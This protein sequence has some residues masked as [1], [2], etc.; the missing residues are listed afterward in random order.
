MLLA[1]AA[2]A[3]AQP[4]FEIHGRVV[5]PGIGA[6]A[7]A[8]VVINTFDEA[9]R[10]VRSDGQG[11]FR[12]SVEHA[13][14]YFVTAGKSG[15]FGSMAR[16]LRQP[17]LLTAAQPVGECVVEL[18]QGGQ[19][20]GRVVDEKTR[21]P[22]AGVDVYLL[23][24]TWNFGQVELVKAVRQSVKTESDGRFLFPAGLMP[25]DYVVAAWARWDGAQASGS[26]TKADTEA[27]DATYEEQYWPGGGDATSS[28]PVHLDSRGYG[29]VGAVYVRK[30]E[31]Y[32]AV[33]TIGKGCTEDDQVKLILLKRDGGKGTSLG[34][35]ECGSQ[36]LLRGLDPGS[37]AL[38]AVSSHQ[39]GRDDLE[40]ALT[41]G[42][43]FEIVDKN[44][45]VSVP[46][47]PISVIEGQLVVGEGVT[48][49]QVTPRIST[50][51]VDVLPGAEAL[52]ETFLVWGDNGRFRLGVT[53][54]AQRL[55]VSPFAGQHYVKEIRYGGSLVNDMV[56][57]A[58]SGGPPKLEIVLSDLKS[59]ATG[60]VT[61]GSR[62]VVDAVVLV[63]PEG[64][65]AQDLA[66]APPANNVTNA[67]GNFNV[68]A[69]PGAYRIVAVTRDGRER[70]NQPGV[71][72]RALGTAQRVTIVAGSMQSVE[73]RLLDPR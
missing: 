8:E 71:M 9:N 30:K 69:A 64:R 43:L 28:Q 35:F 63:I 39:G 60:V 18:V 49:A 44:V 70:L 47:Q 46:L 36:V 37:Y 10:M 61:D 45:A 67:Q 55:S 5:E 31:Q 12:V 3:W 1:A 16:T 6:I 7:D 72:E 22:V 15:Y 57:P 41:G 20:G 38:Y 42:G 51:P 50:R 14:T 66:S 11:N 54:Y 33:A 2:V 68:N 48:K 19:V 13:G 59:G 29:D 17:V 32:R 34:R 73:V 56:L 62:L 27:T 52:D 58:G 65:R 23:H 24:K 26:F 53:P 4:K 25:G 40:A 21:E